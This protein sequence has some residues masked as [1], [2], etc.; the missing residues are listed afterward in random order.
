MKLEEEE[1]DG[2]EEEEEKDGGWRAEQVDISRK[3]F[4]DL[5]F[6]LFKKNR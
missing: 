6:R 1:K 3:Q 2:G 4:T 5:T